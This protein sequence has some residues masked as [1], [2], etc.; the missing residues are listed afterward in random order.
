[1]SGSSVLGSMSRLARAKKKPSR[2]KVEGRSP[3]GGGSGM[4]S[5]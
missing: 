2:L 4:Y 5:G 3:L 1:V